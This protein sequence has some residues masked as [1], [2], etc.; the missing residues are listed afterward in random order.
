MA[1]VVENNDDWVEYIP[2]WGDNRESGVKDPIKCMI[3]HISQQD[4]DGLTDSVI[5]EQ[6]KGY[7]KNKSMKWSRAQR[8]MVDKHV[9][10]IKNVGARKDGEISAVKTMSDM[11]NIAALRGL[12]AEIADALDATNNLESFEVKNL[13]SSSG[14]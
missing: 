7:R 1:I 2:E 8:D 6:R 14:G 9:K 12:Y 3:K 11:Y 10:D 13:K 5:G 4:Q